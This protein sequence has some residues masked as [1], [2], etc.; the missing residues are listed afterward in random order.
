MNLPL[1]R[2]HAPA[3]AARPSGGSCADEAIERLLPVRMELRWVGTVDG[4]FDPGR[5][6][7]PRWSDLP[8]RRRL[9]LSASVSP[10]AKQVTQLADRLAEPVGEGV[11][12]VG[13]PAR[14]AQVQ[15]EPIRL[16]HVRHADALAAG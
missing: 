4:G 15:M 13:D 2:T 8:L 11:H 5:R 1:F 9:R 14:S 7:R 12:A 16:Q 3:L 6:H 10:S